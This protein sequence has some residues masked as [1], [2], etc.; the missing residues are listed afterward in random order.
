MVIRSQ[1]RWS[2][3]SLVIKDRTEKTA[4][5]NG[6]INLIRPAVFFRT[7]VFIRR[8][9]KF[10]L[11]RH[12]HPFF[13]KKNNFKNVNQRSH[14]AWNE[15]SFFIFILFIYF[16]TFINIFLFFFCLETALG[17]FLEQGKL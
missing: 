4:V 9:Y 13:L 12:N 7:V 14:S 5:L 6:L 2:F 3:R 10:Y 11:K 17:L 16:K 15:V 1:D 8:E